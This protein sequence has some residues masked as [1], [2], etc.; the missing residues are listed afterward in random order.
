M[1]VLIVGVYQKIKF[2]E[3]YK[4]RWATVASEL[5]LKDIF[6]QYYKAINNN[7]AD[8][9]RTSEKRKNKH[10]ETVSYII[11]FVR[12]GTFKY[13]FEETIVKDKIVVK[14]VKASKEKT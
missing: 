1:N 5:I 13:H 11:Q 10:K 2:Q 14:K 8:F 6:Y 4:D 7:S 3:K 9:E 12:L